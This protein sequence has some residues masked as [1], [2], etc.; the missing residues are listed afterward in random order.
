M[1][2]SMGLEC[3]RLSLERGLWVIIGALGVGEVVQEESGVE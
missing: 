3:K 1:D 2:K